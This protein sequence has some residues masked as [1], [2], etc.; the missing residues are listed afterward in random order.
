MRRRFVLVLILA[1]V[2]GLLASFLV[3][4]VL[5][6]VAAAAR[7]DRSSIVVAAVNMGMADT[8][9]SE[10]VKLVP[11]P[12]SSIPSGAIRSVADAENRVVRSSIV[13]GEPLLDAKLAPQL[14]GR[15]GLMPM[16][17]PDG[18]RGVTFKVDDAT[19]ESGFV[20]PNSR[21]DVLVSMSK[22]PGSQDRISKVILQDVGVLAAGQ[23]VELRDN[24][25]VTVTTVTVALSPMQA[26]RL[27]LAQSEGKLTLAMRNLRDNKVVETRGVTSASLLADSSAPAPAPVRTAK[28]PAPRPMEVGAPLPPPKVETYA[29]TVVRGGKSAEHV[30]VRD[31]TQEWVEQTGRK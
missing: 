14:S 5:S 3:Y 27:A 20:L 11:W 19:K 4:R 31:T 15:G 1:S 8:I 29:I 25:P 13:A 26:E 12:N 10:H 18:L 21:V 7:P 16:L 28:A 17:V 9:T 22:T 23:T 2:V 30:F 24:K 6:E